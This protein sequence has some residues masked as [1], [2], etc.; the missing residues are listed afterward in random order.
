M[1]DA[2]R[3]NEAIDILLE[4]MEAMA[5]AGRHWHPDEA[6]MLVESLL[7][8]R[9]RVTDALA[10]F[11]DASWPAEM[12]QL[13]GPCVDTARVLLGGYEELETVDPQL[14]NRS[15]RA[16]S[17]AQEALYPIAWAHRSINRFYLPPERRDDEELLRRLSTEPDTSR[18]GVMHLA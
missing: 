12:A 1:A 14:A 18:V 6:P 17:L 3:L 7:P 10:T 9:Q 13:R 16:N 15:L 4:A 5:R 11:E 8:Q 2:E